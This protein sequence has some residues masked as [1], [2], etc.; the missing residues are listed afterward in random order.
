[1]STE[2]QSETREFSVQTDVPAGESIQIQQTMGTCG[3]S[4]VNTEM[5]RSLSYDLEGNKQVSYFEI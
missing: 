1:M 2:A 4:N 5:F 3:G